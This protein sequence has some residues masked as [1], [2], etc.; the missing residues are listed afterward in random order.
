MEQK[1]LR[2]YA[3]LIARVG[4]KIKPGQEVIIYAQLD[5][6]DFVVLLCEECYK[7]GAARVSVEWSHQPIERLSVDYCSLEALSRVDK[8]QEE[9]LKYQTEN[10]PVKIYLLSE[11]PNGLD[12]IDQAKYS[13]AQQARYKI[14]KPYRDAMDNKYQWCIA[15]VPGVAWAKKVFKGLSDQDAVER[16]WE[17]ILFTSRCTDDPIDAWNKH[18]ADLMARCEYLNAM[19]IRELQFKASNG[20]DLKVG[21]IPSAQFLG[22][23]EATLSGNDFNPNIPSEEVFIT[24]MRGKAEGKVVASRPLSYRGELIENFSITF[25]RGRVESVS[26]EKG[27]ELLKELVNMDA[28][29]AMLGECALVPYHSPISESGILF[30]NTLFDENAACH[31]ALGEGFANSIKGFE[32]LSLSECRELGVNESVIH[33]DF[34]IGTPDLSVIGIT[35][36][37]EQVAIFKN[38]DWAF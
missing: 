33:E 37:G 38:G 25:K 3:G 32:K 34:M 21:M 17:A 9:K 13:K 27:E 20:T 19:N 31:L 36:S 24:P 6:P 1:R 10:L 35:E 7:T 23:K 29:A 12:G 5:C 18:N 15:A 26:A 8:W 4:A 28:G 2:D 22:G 14:I 11:D 16:L 30:Y